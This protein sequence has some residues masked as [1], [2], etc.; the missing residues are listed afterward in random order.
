[1]ALNVEFFEKM[2]L[3]QKAL[4]LGILILA[5]G[6]IWYGVF[7]DPKVQELAAQESKY[8]DKLRQMDKLRKM[9]EDE[10]NL[11]KMIDDKRRTIEK[12]KEILPTQTEMDQLLLLIDDIGKKNGIYFENFKPSKEVPRG[13]LYYEVPISLD[14]KGNYK[15]IMNFFYEVANLKRIVKFTD[16]KMTSGKAETGSQISVKCTAMT[17]KFYGK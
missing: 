13:S 8:N 6:A 15:Y 5:V 2:S 17:Y 1:M 14:F 7:Y 9:R 16:V 10:K 12:Y 3:A 4:I 11:L